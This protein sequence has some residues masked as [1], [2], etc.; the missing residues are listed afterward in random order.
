MRLRDSLSNPGKP[1]ARLLKALEQAGETALP[2]VEPTSADPAVATDVRECRMLSPDEVTELVEAYRHGAEMNE[3]SR[4]YGVHRH[5][6]D[7]HLERAGISKRQMTK[8]TPARVEKA[9]ELYG[10]GLSTN[11]IGKKFG[12]SGSTVW[13]AL[14]RAGVKMRKPGA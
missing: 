11:Q 8:M 6:V 9:K 1:L 12:I 2:Q 10:Q 7:R 5:T 14:K 3:L 4:R 13:K